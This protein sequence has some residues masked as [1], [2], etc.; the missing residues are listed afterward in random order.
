MRKGIKIVK[1]IIAFVGFLFYLTWLFK[2]IEIEPFASLG[3]WVQIGC[4][5]C[6]F[7]FFITII[8][9]VFWPDKHKIS[10]KE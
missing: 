9:S 5:I 3:N 6:S 1:L 4:V 8:S 7:I 2:L 10:A